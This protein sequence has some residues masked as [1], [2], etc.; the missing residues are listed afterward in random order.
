MTKESKSEKFVRLAEERVTK[1][2]GELRKIG[3]LAG[4]VYEYT[5][6]QVQAIITALNDGISNISVRFDEPCSAE[7][8][9]FKF[10][11]WIVDGDYEIDNGLDENDDDIETIVHTDETG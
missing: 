4:P 8:E 3:N 9:D 11:D 6:K 2:L 10:V 5:E 7:N 1:A